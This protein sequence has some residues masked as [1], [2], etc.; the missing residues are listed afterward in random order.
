[1]WTLPRQDLAA[2]VRP[3]WCLTTGARGLT[4]W[5]QRVLGTWSASMLGICFWF[6]HSIVLASLVMREQ[7]ANS[8]LQCHSYTHLYLPTLSLH[9]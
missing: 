6:R 9:G 8:L 2:H 3:H 7:F 5:L 4:Q 1:M